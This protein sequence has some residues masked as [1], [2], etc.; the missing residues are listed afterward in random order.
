M[1]LPKIKGYLS[2]KEKKGLLVYERK[3]SDPQE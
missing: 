2:E 3:N 1:E